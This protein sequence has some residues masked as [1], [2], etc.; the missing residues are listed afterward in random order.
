MRN[1][2]GSLFA[3]LILAWAPHALAQATP[4][5]IAP[6]NTAWGQ[7]EPGAWSRLRI[8]IETIAPDG[9][10]SDRSTTVQTTTL[11]S[12]GENGVE[13]KVDATVDV[14]G[15]QFDA[16]SQSVRQL[17]SGQSVTSTAEVTAQSLGEGN[18][19]I[20]GKQ[21]ACQIE[22][23]QIVEKAGRT[24][25]KTFYSATLYPHVLRT[26]STTTDDRGEAISQT[27]GEVIALEMPYHTM[28]GSTRQVAVWQES[29]RKP[30]GAVE[31]SL[32]FRGNGVPGG[33]V[34]R[35]SKELDAAG[36]LVRRSMLELID[37]SDKPT[38]P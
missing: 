5:A 38:A 25:A 32:A 35:W 4:S 1:L 26:E 16:P 27:N 17:F 15:K 23:A 10:V 11:V 20:E 13:L 36:N 19:T 6:A 29:T 14:A 24:L 31:R 3:C 22:Q 9:S 33:V 28:S 30:K 34:A 18:V 12:I 21:I 8:V 37:Y 7:F 2:V